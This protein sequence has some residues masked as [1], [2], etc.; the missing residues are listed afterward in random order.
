M[1]RPILGAGALIGAMLGAALSTPAQAADMPFAAEPPAPVNEEMLEWGSNWYLRGDVGM[2]GVS[3]TGLNGVI[4]S[5]DFPNNWTIGLGGGYKFNN[6]FRADF[7]VD[8]ESLYNRNAIAPELARACPQGF[9][10]VPGDTTG[11]QFFV[12]SPLCTPSVRNRTESMAVLFNAYVDLGNWYGFTPYVGAGVGTNVLY[13][14]AGLNWFMGNG[15]P[16]HITFAHPVTGQQFYQNWDT[17]YQ[18]TFL[19]FAYAFMGG[20]SYDIDENW[21]VDVGYRYLNLGNI[22]G[23]DRYN[24]PVS[25]DL[26]SHQVRVGFRYMVN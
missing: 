18:G 3:P 15:L 11:T 14:Q 7:T 12:N 24:Y 23:V 1:F 10:P 26:T 19:R 6:W 2:A 17:R 5:P 13:Q 21:K 9:L 16:Y 20:V 22:T 4:L 25:R 8:Y